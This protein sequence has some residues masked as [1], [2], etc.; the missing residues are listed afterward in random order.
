MVNL[1]ELTISLDTIKGTNPKKMNDKYYVNL[2]QMD[3][4]NKKN[5]IICQTPKLKINNDLTTD[6]ELTRF[7]TYNVKDVKMIEKIQEIDD[8]MLQYVKDRRGLLFHGKE[9]TDEMIEMGQ[10]S[11][12]KD[13]KNNKEEK[14]LTI[15]IS[16]EI[17]VYNTTK[18]SI[19]FNK[20][21][22][23]DVTSNI[24]QLSGIWFTQSRWGICWKSFQMRIH[25]EKEIP[26]QYLFNDEEEDSDDE[27][28]FLPPGV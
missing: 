11:S 28:I 18:E 12:L 9:I 16:D 14:I 10:I 6:G 19:D 7:V 5:K 15:N 24:I 22:K 25:N 4:E 8:V 1:T 13:N 21:K 17:K 27:E 2:Y 23:G 26:K 3:E 20:I